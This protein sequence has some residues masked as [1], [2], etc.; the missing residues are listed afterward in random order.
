MKNE[1]APGND[2]V[3]A[4]LIKYGGE[5]MSKIAGDDVEQHIGTGASGWGQ[6][7]ICPPDFE[8]CHVFCVQKFHAKTSSPEKCCT[9][10]GLLWIWGWL[11]L[12]HETAG[13]RT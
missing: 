1:K 5:A 3:R 12:R 8:R 10:R 4:E 9:P 2:G 6:K 11:K 13:F 7:G